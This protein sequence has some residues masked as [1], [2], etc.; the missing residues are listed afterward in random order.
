MLYLRR[1]APR[2]IL[3]D[4]EAVADWNECE[5]AIQPRESLLAL[6]QFGLL[7]GGAWGL[8]IGWLS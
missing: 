6:L 2:A 3:N 7:L 8:L 1:P 4:V 5:E